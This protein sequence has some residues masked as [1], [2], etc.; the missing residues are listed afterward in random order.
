MSEVQLAVRSPT[1]RDIEFITSS[2]LRSFRDGYFVSTVPN[3]IYFNQ[4]H[5]IL[6]KLIPRA[7]CLIACNEMDPDHIY[8]Y[9]I[10]E[11][12]DQHLVV[13]YIYVKDS[14]R[15][16]GVAKKLVQHLLRSLPVV[17]DR[18]ITTHQT[19]KSKALLHGWKSWDLAPARERYGIE[20]LYNPYLLFYSLPEKWEQT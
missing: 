3:R 5:K 15:R 2:W 17:Q 14:L 18:I 10:A 7:T 16:F 19:H 11:V 1:Q 13:H 12:M 9:V 6:E 4:H 20:F 8:G